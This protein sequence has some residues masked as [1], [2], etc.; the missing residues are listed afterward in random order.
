MFQNVP[1]HLPIVGHLV[2][3]CCYYRW[4]FIQRNSFKRKKPDAQIRCCPTHR[5]IDRG[6]ALL[7]LTKPQTEFPMALPTPTPF[8]P[9]PGKPHH[10]PQRDILMELQPSSLP[11]L[12]LR[13]E[14]SVQ[15]HSPGLLCGPHTCQRPFPNTS[16]PHSSAGQILS[17]VPSISRLTSSPNTS[18]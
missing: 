3:I 13:E 9:Q 14:A 17:K 8:L 5:M 1:N 15:G 18:A 10:I 6:P 7:Y 2:P 12:T 4:G 16:P 11:G